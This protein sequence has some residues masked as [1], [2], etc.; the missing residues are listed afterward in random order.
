MENRSNGKYT[1]SMAL[2]NKTKWNLS[3]SDSENEAAD[4]HRFIVIEFLEEVCLAK[5]LPFL[6]EKLFLQGLLQKLLRKP[7]TTTC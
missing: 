3:E 1:A 4:F 5:L 6:I 7:G 2:S